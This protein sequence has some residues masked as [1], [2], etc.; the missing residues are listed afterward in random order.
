MAD[1]PNVALLR[2]GYEAFAKGDLDTLR[3]LFADDIVWHSPGNNILSGD[4]KGHE[5]V[6]GFFGRIVQ[7]TGGNFSND[8][9][10]VL[11]NDEHAAVMVN[12]HS[13]RNG[14]TL[15]APVVHIFHVK[16]GKV[17]EF[18]AFGQD[19]NELDAFWS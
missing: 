6:F 14:K 1:H 16:D 12:A 3:G 18:W 15:D 17:T 2:K 7:E 10:D 9:H 19:S 5:E 11:A 8:I 13:E 4:Y